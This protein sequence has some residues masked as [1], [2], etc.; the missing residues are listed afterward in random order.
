M[1]ET[2]SKLIL[3]IFECRIVVIDGRIYIVNKNVMKPDF[4]SDILHHTFT[5]TRMFRM[6]VLEG[7]SLACFN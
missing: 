6:S 4:S 5:S 2:Y 7:R 1:M 3:S